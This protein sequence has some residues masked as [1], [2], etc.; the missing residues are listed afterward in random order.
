MKTHLLSFVCCF[1]CT[2]NSTA[3]LR[4]GEK[5][6][7]EVELVFAPEY[8]FINI[9]AYRSLPE[10]V[11]K[12]STEFI[13]ALASGNAAK[14]SDFTTRGI[15]Q[16]K[17]NSNA[18]IIERLHMENFFYTGVVKCKLAGEIHDTYVL[19]GTFVGAD[20]SGPFTYDTK[21]WPP[22]PSGAVLPVGFGGNITADIWYHSD[23]AWL[24]RPT[25]RGQLY[26]I[27]A[28]SVQQLLATPNDS[29]ISQENLDAILHSSRLS[30]DSERE[31]IR[32]AARKRG[33]IP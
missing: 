28:E 31:A 14:A 19:L 3:V 25:R 12:R 24:V 13:Q 11:G 29:W 1:V 9:E 4:G 2:I 15:A 20:T 22:L 8:M 21:F 6:K 23:G 27:S 30:W 7:G 32:N 16:D 10:E 5:P 33:I 17:I 18:S 26:F